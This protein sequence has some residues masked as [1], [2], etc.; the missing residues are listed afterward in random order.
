MARRRHPLFSTGRHAEESVHAGN[1][2]TIK[3]S[4]EPPLCSTT[5]SIPPTFTAMWPDNENRIPR[6]YFM[7]KPSPWRWL[8]L[9]LFVA[10]LIAFLQAIV[11]LAIGF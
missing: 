11:R 4:G 3:A 2:T 6:D 7:P 1:A 9:A 5:G 10:V 8:G